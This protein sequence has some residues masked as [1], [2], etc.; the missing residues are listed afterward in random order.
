MPIT[1]SEPKALEI[2]QI[3]ANSFKILGFETHT[4]TDV[5]NDDTIFVRKEARTLVDGVITARTPMRGTQYTAVTVVPVF[6]DLVKRLA[7][8]LGLEL[9]PVDDPTIALAFYVAFRDAL[10][11]A[12]RR[13]GEF[14]ADAT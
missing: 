1:T 2:V 10:Y 5:P 8:S 7:I 12:E 3:M 9:P 11:D 14:P 6:A 13:S 4:E